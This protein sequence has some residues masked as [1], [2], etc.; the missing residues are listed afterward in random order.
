[1]KNISEMYKKD[2]VGTD[3]RIL[4][5]LD[6]FVVKD[7]WTVSSL[8]V[9]INNDA[10]EDLGKKKPFLGSLRLDVGVKYIKAMGDN[11]VLNKSLKD[12]ASHL[13]E[14]RESNNASNLLNM[15][16]VDEKGRDVGA[17]ED[18]M[19]DD[20][21]WSIPSVLVRVNK[22][23]SDIMNVKKPMLSNSRVSLSTAH[24]RSASDK[25]MLSVTT[26]RL[27]EILDQAPVKAV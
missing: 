27:S 19:L 7:D 2:I 14:Y 20:K 17:V 15:E 1:M 25:I 24:I 10:V 23:I 16:I 3:G 5:T 26:E 6:S 22:D 13:T 8:T 11:I 18:I 21:H 4:G 12:L 9:K